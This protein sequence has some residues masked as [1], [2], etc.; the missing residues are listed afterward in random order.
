MASDDQKRPIRIL[1]VVGGMDIGGVETWLMHVLR[2]IDRDCYRFD[3]LTH[4]TKSCFYDKEI[5]SF[6]CRIIP[7]LHPSRPW[8]YARNF[9]RILKEYG[10]YDV[11]HSHVH[12]FSGFTLML[13]HCAGVSMR[14]AHSHS[15]PLVNDD[16]ARFWR[17]LYLRSTEWF[18]RH[19]ATTGLA[20]SGAAATN[21]FGYDWECDPRWKVLY[22]GIDFEPFSR[23][24]DKIEI[25]REFGIAP[26]A[27]VLGHVG[28]LAEPKNHDFLLDIFAEFLRHEPNAYLLLVGDGPLREAV[29][30]KTQ[31]LGLTGKVVFTGARSDVP[32]LMLGAMDVFVFPSHYEGIPLTLVEAQ[33]AGL[34]AVI[35]DTISDEVIVV[36]KLVKSLSLRDGLTIWIQAVIDSASSRKLGSESQQLINDSKFN[37]IHSAAEL[38]NLYSSDIKVKSVCIP[39]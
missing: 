15:N 29:M 8:Q 9:L 13:A 3:F 5:K 36:P 26:D 34:P 14:I 24:V 11:V 1:H 27:F 6:G 25:R 7:C 23:N 18:I 20:C 39:S 32:R 30:T 22:C 37:V 33:A 28:R 17:K 21:L 31:R 12:K 16:R 4:T 10:P 19:H 35:S 38:C 2:R